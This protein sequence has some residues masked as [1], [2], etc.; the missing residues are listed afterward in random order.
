MTTGWGADGGPDDDDTWTDRGIEIVAEPL[1]YRRSPLVALLVIA[2]IPTLGLIFVARWADRR[3][4]VYEADRS[5]GSFMD[6][7]LDGGLAV[8]GTAR[9]PDDGTAPGSGIAPGP[10]ATL[11]TGILDFRRVPSLIASDA[12]VA[13]L[14]TAV[15]PVFSFIGDRSCASVAVD[16]V[17]VTSSNP[18]LPVIPA[19]N[20]KLLVAFAA[21]DLLGA[22]HTFTTTV[23]APPI[24][25]GVIDGDV[26]LVGGGDPLLTSADF[27]PDGGGLAVTSPTSFDALADGLVAAGVTRIRGTVIGDA[28][29]YDDEF[30]VDEWAEGV[31]Y[32]EAGPYDALLANDAQV[33]GRSGREDDPAAGAAREFVRLLNDRD[34]RV[35]DGWGS[36]AASNLLPVVASVQSVPLSDVIAEMLGTS[37]DNTAEM[38]V[39]EIGVGASGA[40][41]RA[42]GLAA[43]SASLEAAGVP[44]A[45]VE[46]HDGSGLSASNR[47]TCSAILAILQRA[48]GGPIDAGLPVAGV[49][50]TLTG[51][52]VDGPMVGRLR[53]K[54]GTLGNPPLEEDP[55]AV[56][57]L[58]GYV[59]P[60]DG[61]GPGTIQ[62]VLIAN[63]PN[64]SDENI[65][66]PLWG[67]FAE[68][69]ATYPGGPATDSLGP[70]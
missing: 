69:L 44:M 23:T 45:G 67:A 43:I 54:T 1:R 2:I 22:D 50:G 26:F 56:K 66:R 49:S 30:V 27:V 37:D 21:L 15:D 47:V 70:R 60:R 31:A 65:Y 42:A 20:Q 5:S 8:D 16:G 3:A 18:D 64:V 4:D 63:T 25:D 13:Q 19:S 38:L 41:T 14:R 55:P 68:R 57:A 11:T 39:K 53:A 40:G 33:V 52:F 9:T 46:L 36:G 6:V 29:R 58:A 51:E 61:P 59:D 7:E 17:P 28:T 62:F 10:A 35:D 48:Q 12:S 32:V 24:E 34:I